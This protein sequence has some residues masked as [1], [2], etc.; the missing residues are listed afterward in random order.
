D[1]VRAL[2][3]IPRSRSSSLPTSASSHAYPR[4]W[5][6]PW[7]RDPGIELPL[8]LVINPIFIT[9]FL[10]GIPF[11]NPYPTPP[12]HNPERNLAI[13]CAALH[14]PSQHIHPISSLR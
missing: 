6:V 2:R 3:K 11:K 4:C 12:T 14:S 5:I 8:L 10:S 9:I 13:S 1:L 7:A